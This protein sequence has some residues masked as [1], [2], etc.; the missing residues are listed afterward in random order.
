M[1]KFNIVFYL[2]E[3][4][5]NIDLP[6]MYEKVIIFRVEFYILIKKQKIFLG[7]YKTIIM[8]LGPIHPRPLGVENFFVAIYAL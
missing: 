6:I 7:S 2:K 3:Y 1:I 5:L 4:L 8:S